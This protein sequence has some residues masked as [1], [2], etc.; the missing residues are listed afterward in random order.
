MG[1]F[2]LTIW[3]PTN[4][5]EEGMKIAATITKLPPY[6]KKWQQLAASDEKGAKSYNILYVDDSKIDEAIK[7][8]AKVMSLYWKLE[9]FTYKIE[10][11]A[12]QRDFQKIM[13]IKI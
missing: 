5:V 9:G 11:V 12:S 8:V 6:I 10:P 13:A 4:Q 2:M 1:I 7:W 3:M